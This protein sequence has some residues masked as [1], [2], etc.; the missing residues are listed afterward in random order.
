MNVA[1]LTPRYFPEV[2]RGTE[3]VVR[4]V[5]RQLVRRGHRARVVTS[6]RGLPSRRDDDGVAVLRL[7]R[8]PGEGR[9]RRHAFADHLTH[10][11]LTYAALLAGDDDLA[12]AFYP[13]DGVAA[14]RWGRR[15]DRPVVLSWTGVPNRP[16]LA[17]RRLNLEVIAR[18]V[19][20]ADA[21]VVP[22]HAAAWA[23]ER[24]LGVDAQVI[25]P[26]V[27]LDVFAPTAPRSPEP[28]IF[29]AAAADDD[30][31]RVPLLLEALPAVRRARPGARL[32]LVRPAD[33][34]VAARLAAV[35]GVELV[36]P[37]DDPRALAARYSSAWVSALPAYDEA[38]GLVLAEALACGTPVVGR[39][40]AGIPEVVGD[41]PVGR[42]FDGDDP[43]A[44]ATALL[45]GLEL[46]ESDGIADACRRR[47]AAFSTDEA[48]RRHADLYRSLLTG[49]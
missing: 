48:G 18:S 11:P 4:E 40:D 28:A 24:W 22:S 14:V 9:L 15:R 7:P 17:A 35:D 21:V 13:T 44:V 34:R 49:S 42:L 3:R 20:A 25:W 33:A 8:P 27:D 6:H 39:R 5:A 23:M 41:A 1:L 46:A 31:K 12:H 38:F 47:A 30:R 10:V 2:R 26:G 19:L 37:L 16:T 36:E 43:G 32:L 29:C 45:E